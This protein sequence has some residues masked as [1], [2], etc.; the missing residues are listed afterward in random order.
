MKLFLDESYLVYAP[1]NVYVTSYNFVHHE[2]N[3][4]S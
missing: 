1:H 3:L 2:K 4:K